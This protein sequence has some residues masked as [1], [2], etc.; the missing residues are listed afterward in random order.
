MDKNHIK[1]PENESAIAGLAGGLAHEIRNPLNS[2]KINLQLLAEDLAENEN[3]DSQKRLQLVNEEITRL[4]EILNHFLR[5]ARLARPKMEKLDIHQ[6]ISEI[7]TFIDPLL[8]KQKITLKTEIQKDLPEISGD[9]DQLKQVLLN[10]LLNSMESIIDKGQILMTVTLEG[11]KVQLS[12]E[13]N[14]RGIAKEHRRKIFEPFFST[15]EQGTGLGLPIAAKI[16]KEHGG[17][18]FLDEKTEENTTKFVLELPFG[19]GERNR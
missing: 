15:K 19:T 18:L 14:G 11:N 1:K 17:R 3:R 12:V 6:L 4:E 7:G 13:D 10:L 2:I 9:R 16:A 5:Y 8:N